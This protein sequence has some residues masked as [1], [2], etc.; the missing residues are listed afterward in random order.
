MSTNLETLEPLQSLLS[1][2]RVTSFDSIDTFE[3]DAADKM[4]KQALD[5]LEDDKNSW[6]EEQEELLD[7]LI[8]RLDEIY[9]SME[10]RAQ[11]V[12]LFQQFSQEFQSTLSPVALAP[13]EALEQEFFQLAEQLE[14]QEWRTPTYQKVENGYANYLQGN[15]DS[16]IQAL[17]EMAAI[18]N[19]ARMSYQQTSVAD[20]EVTA[21]SVVGHKLLTEGL[22]HWEAALEIFAELPGIGD[23]SEPIQDSET[24]E[25]HA[26]EA[27]AE[28]EYGNRLLVILPKFNQ[29]IKNQQ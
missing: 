13:G 3:W 17:E 19:K 16:L 4:V 6:E 25:S 27:L 20:S 11:A 9:E 5:A 10:D 21:E 1:W 12:S 24:L 22:N 26:N 2:I 23:Q 7:L 8:E 15:P 28:A 29:R 14:A 18:I